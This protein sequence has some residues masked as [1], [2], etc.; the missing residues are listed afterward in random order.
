MVGDYNG[1]AERSKVH[2]ANHFLVFGMVACASFSARS[3]LHSSGCE[4]IN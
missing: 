3:L 2:G 1:L 4:T